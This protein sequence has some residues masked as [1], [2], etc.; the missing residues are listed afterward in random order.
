[1]YNSMAYGSGASN[2]I[3][4]VGRAFA[5][6]RFIKHH[7]GAGVTEISRE[8]DMS[9]SGVHKHLSTM[10]EEGYLV[11][12]EGTYRLSFK[13]VA[14]SEFVKRNSLF[15]TV[16]VPEIDDLSAETG[17]GV[18]LGAFENDT[19]YCIYQVES[20]TAVA[21]DVDVGDTIEFHSTAAGKAIA[22]HLKESALED[23]LAGEL[24]EK[25]AVTVTD[26]DALRD[27]FATIRE[28]GLAYEDEENV[29]GMRAVGAPVLSPDGDVLGAIAVSGPLSLL[30]EDRF[31][32]EI[33][34]VL[35]QTKN[36]IEVKYS[37]KQRK[38]VEQGSHVPR[39]FY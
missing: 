15:Y 12:E 35:R 29:R 16:S 39:E 36:F 17:N 34:A 26:E 8:L 23:V 10:V 20:D 28:D 31:H 3:D 4:A 2:T 37:L 9:K 19:A 14:D 7:N 38:S 1:M 5:I 27:E 6:L 25:T 13:F 18:Y 30:T 33:P 21:T 11:N 24:P 22:A 32:D